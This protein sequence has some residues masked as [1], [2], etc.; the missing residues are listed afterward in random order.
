MSSHQ[1]G[2]LR[3]LALTVFRMVPPRPSHAMIR[4]LAPTFSMGA[5]AV[6]EHDGAVLALRQLHRTGW[7]LPGG[8]V[9]RGEIPSRTVVREVAEETGLRVDPGDVFATVI[10]EHYR[11]VDVIYRVS[12]PREP[13]VRPA[14]EAVDARW[15]RLEEL[16]EPDEPTRRI[17]AAV[18]AAQGERTVGTVVEDLP[19]V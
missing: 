15:F 2:P 12:C 3:R 16:P 19:P 17:I 11:H 14:S 13:K 18:Q 8:L 5:V 1:P 4:A 6:I 9:D 7:S 10:D